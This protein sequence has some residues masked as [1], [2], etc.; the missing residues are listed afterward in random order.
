MKKIVL[1]IFILLHMTMPVI[2]SSPSLNSPLNTNVQSEPERLI[3]L[4][5]T[6]MQNN[7]V[8]EVRKF[9]KNNY[10][11]QF[12]SMPMEIHLKVI[13]DLHTDFS[14]YVI[15]QKIKKN[16]KIIV[17]IKSPINKM[18]QLTLETDGSRPA[19]IFN[20]DIKDPD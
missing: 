14:H 5:L 4:F 9:I 1:I 6:T 3:I 10:S 19:K 18:K 16:N 8:A 11:P 17:V 20:I 15:F 7:N 12:L 2:Y 13:S